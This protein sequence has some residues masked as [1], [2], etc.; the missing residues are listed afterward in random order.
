MPAAWAAHGAVA[1]LPG[2]A[3]AT[4]AHRL[5][6]HLV[7]PWWQTAAAF[8]LQ[9]SAPALATAWAART[10]ARRDAAGGGAPAVALAALAALVVSVAVGVRAASALL[11]EVV[12]A[13][14]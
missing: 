10:A 13:V 9:L 8:L 4:A 2:A 7:Q 5:A 11:P 3:V 12:N 1:L 14:E 6:F